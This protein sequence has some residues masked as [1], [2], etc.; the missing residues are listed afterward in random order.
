M[1][2]QLEIAIS[3]IQPLSPL[4]RKQLLQILIQGEL[5]STSGTELK[6]LSTQFRQG[7]SLKQLLETQTPTTIHNLEGMAADFWPEEDS[8][9]DFLIF[10]QQQRQE[11]TL[12]RLKHVGF[13]KSPESEP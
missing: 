6:T 13:F 11:L 4:E 10:L 1:T 7:I 3:A 2:P 8:I 12:P 9:E 5:S